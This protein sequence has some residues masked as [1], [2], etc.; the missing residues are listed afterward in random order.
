[1]LQDWGTTEDGHLLGEGMLDGKEEEHILMTIL[2]PEVCRN[3]LLSPTKQMLQDLSRAR[4]RSFLFKVATILP[5]PP[6][7]L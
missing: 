3:F 5:W 1:M 4:L 6:F 2:H 7:P